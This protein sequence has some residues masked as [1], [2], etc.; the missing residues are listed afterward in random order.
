MKKNTELTFEK[1]L[2]NFL[3]DAIMNVPVILPENTEDAEAVM[4]LE[5][6][7]TKIVSGK[8][9][10]RD[11]ISGLKK[12]GGNVSIDMSIPKRPDGMPSTFYPSQ[13][14]I[15]C[16]CGDCGFASV[17]MDDLSVRIPNEDGTGQVVIEVVPTG[18]LF[19]RRKVSLD[20]CCPF[21]ERDTCMWVQACLGMTIH[22]LL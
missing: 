6:L 18:N 21:L 8:D 1:V 5:E 2:R 11:I 19:P 10:F 9:I 15:F 12:T 7:I 14:D 13:I 3:G 20:I 4:A 22:T 16:E 17:R